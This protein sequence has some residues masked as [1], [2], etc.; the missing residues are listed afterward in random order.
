MLGW[1][2]GGGDDTKDTD[3]WETAPS[4]QGCRQWLPINVSSLPGLKLPWWKKRKGRLQ[5][6]TQ[7]GCTL[8]PW[9]F[10]GLQGTQ[11]EASISP[12]ISVLS[13]WSGDRGILPHIPVCM[14]TNASI[15]NLSLAVPPRSVTVE[16]LLQLVKEE[17][18]PPLQFRTWERDRIKGAK[19]E[20]A[21]YPHAPARWHIMKD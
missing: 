11:G 12:S 8:A 5:A 13:I 9:C 14:C 20:S 3:S 15:T 1:G 17:P 16:L 4:S 6:G 21:A 2:G 7:Q 10:H 18:P 19:C